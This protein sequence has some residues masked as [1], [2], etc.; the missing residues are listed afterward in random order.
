MI[1]TEEASQ[2]IIL[3][4]H[5]YMAEMSDVISDALLH[6]DEIRRSNTRPETVRLYYKGIVDTLV[7][8]KWVCVVVKYLQDEAY[9]PHRLRDWLDK[10]GRAVPM[11][12][13]RKV[14]VWY[15][16]AGD[17]LDVSWDTAHAYYTA[18]SDE[19]VM[20]LVDMEGNVQGFKIDG[21]SA[22]KDKPLSV[23]LLS[24]KSDTKTA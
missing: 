19:R 9:V 3:P 4:L 23:D 10:D 16:E 22:I 15:D 14:N 20:A 24:A 11:N 1:L 13:H 8:D 6:P 18:T 7:G 5:S 2:H 12:Q 17:Y 21:I